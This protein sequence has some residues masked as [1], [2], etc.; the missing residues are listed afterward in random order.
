[1]RDL[2]FNTLVCKFFTSFEKASFFLNTIDDQG[3]MSIFALIP[4]VIQ[5][6]EAEGYLY[7]TFSRFRNVIKF[8][9]NM[10]IF[11]LL[12]FDRIVNILRNLSVF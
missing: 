2:V 1:M 7:K 10:C 5:G 12:T 4:S 3:E 9:I 6:K 11:L 8:E